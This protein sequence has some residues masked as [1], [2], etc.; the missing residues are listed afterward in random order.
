MVQ[1][2][3]KQYQVIQFFIE[4]TLTVN[5]VPD[6]VVEPTDF[7]LVDPSNHRLFNKRAK[8]WYNNEKRKISFKDQQKE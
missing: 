5:R 1:T 6:Q 2:I 7:E 8:V 4:D 3:G